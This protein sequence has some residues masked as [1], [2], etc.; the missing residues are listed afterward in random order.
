MLSVDP[1]P[2]LIW[3]SYVDSS[4]FG[5]EDRAA[6]H[7]RC[8]GPAATRI[9]VG[10]TRSVEQRFSLYPGCTYDQ[11]RWLG[12]LGDDATLGVPLGHAEFMQAQLCKCALEVQDTEAL[13]GA[14]Y[15]AAQLLPPECGAFYI[16]DV[17]GDAVAGYAAVL[18]LA[19]RAFTAIWRGDLDYQLAWTAAA[20]GCALLVRWYLDSN[21]VRDWDIAKARDDYVRIMYNS[22]VTSSTYAETLAA[23][24]GLRR[25]CRAERDLGAQWRAANPYPRLTIPGLGEWG[26][27][28]DPYAAACA[29]HFLLFL[30]GALLACISAWAR[31]R[32][33]APAFLCLPAPAFLC[34][35]APAFPCLPAPAFPCLPAPALPL[36]P[37]R[38]RTAQRPKLRRFRNNHVHYLTR[39]PFSAR[40]RPGRARQRAQFDALSAHYPFRAKTGPGPGPAY[41][42]QAY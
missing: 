37:R 23:H 38:P 39:P 29:S 18:G 13:R 1:T 5:F 26:M 34:L 14:I 20:L 32:G 24:P 3:L 15:R 31:S 21:E 22:D 11:V 9:G 12:G 25:F 19:A 36:P 41:E 30:A 6:A 2:A 8:H 40:G 7:L 17:W 28:I 4:L 33:T 27:L 42:R 16:L 35:P 10:W